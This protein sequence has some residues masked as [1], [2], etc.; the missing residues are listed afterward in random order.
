MIWFPV[1]TKVQLWPNVKWKSFSALKKQFTQLDAV[2]L[3]L[4][5]PC[6]CQYWWWLMTEQGGQWGNQ[7]LELV[8]VHWIIDQLI[9][10]SSKPCTAGLLFVLPLWVKYLCSFLKIYQRQANV[11]NVIIKCNQNKHVCI[12]LCAAT[13]TNEMK[14]SLFFY[15][16]VKLLAA[17]TWWG[18]WKGRWGGG[19][20]SM[21]TACSLHHGSTLFQAAHYWNN[22]R[23]SSPQ[24]LKY[25]FFFPGLQC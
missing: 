5:H 1:T 16:Q 19:R 14:I 7:T 3:F 12:T 2:I 25:I 13:H 4:P 11:I 20:W 10:L 17:C 6:R 24:S 22:S 8:P 23:D 18:W 21:W 15:P 9:P